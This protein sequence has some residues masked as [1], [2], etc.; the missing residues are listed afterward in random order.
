MCALLTQ[1]GEEFLHVVF[2]QIQ[3]LHLVSK[4]NNCTD[5][6]DIGERN[7]STMDGPTCAGNPHTCYIPP[8]NLE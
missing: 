7:Q 6:L 2:E 5:R 8:D 4:S 3:G 1:F